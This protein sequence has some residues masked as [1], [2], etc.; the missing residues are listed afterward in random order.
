MQISK[1]KDFIAEMAVKV[2]ISSGVEVPE[3]MIDLRTGV[4]VDD[5]AVGVKRLVDELEDVADVEA[6]LG[7]ARVKDYVEATETVSGIEIN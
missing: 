4:G 7:G 5:E 3:T 1:F 2:N 6:V